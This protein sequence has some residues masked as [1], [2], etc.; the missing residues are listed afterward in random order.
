MT[1]V[2]K[3]EIREV[4]RDIVLRT[5]GSHLVDIERCL[6]CPPKLTPSKRRIVCVG[7]QVIG[8]ERYF[9]CQIYKAQNEAIVC[10]CDEL[11]PVA[12]FPLTPA[13][14]ASAPTTGTAR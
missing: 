1:S 9:R 7:L 3:K 13:R 8:N 6:Y 4:I 14:P 5:F 10:L 2:S 12:L 11:I